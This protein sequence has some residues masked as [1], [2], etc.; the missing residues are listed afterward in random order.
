MTDA[1]ILPVKLIMTMDSMIGEAEAHRRKEI[2]EQR[3]REEHAKLRARIRRQLAAGA[4]K[5][6]IF[7]FGATVL[8]FLFSYEAELQ[9][10]AKQFGRSLA[11][12]NSRSVLQQAALSYEQEVDEIAK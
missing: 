12:N 8:V 6:F 1:S 3:A 9:G 4:R 5:T 7:L 2:R 10:T 11:S